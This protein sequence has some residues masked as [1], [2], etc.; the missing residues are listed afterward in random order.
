MHLQAYHKFSR[1]RLNSGK[2]ISYAYRVGEHRE[3]MEHSD[4]AWRQLD[5]QQ[6]QT[7][8]DSDGEQLDSTDSHSTY[9]SIG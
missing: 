1:K 9:R 5:V 4:D 2:V 7:N 3:A 8:M 6:W